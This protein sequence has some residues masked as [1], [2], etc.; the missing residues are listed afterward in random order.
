[1]NDYSG[2]GLRVRVGFRLRVLY[3]TW[4]TGLGLGLRVTWSIAPSQQPPR[5]GG[6]DYI[7]KYKSID[8][9][10]VMVGDRLE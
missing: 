3:M 9:F 8:V 10:C 6:R 5:G 1:M 4:S 2:L 7:K